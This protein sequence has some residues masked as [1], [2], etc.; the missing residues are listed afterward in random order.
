[1]DSYLKAKQLL[2]AS[3]LDDVEEMRRFELWDEA[4]SYLSSALHC[5]EHY[6]NDITCTECEHADVVA[7]DTDNC[8]RHNLCI[9]IK[10]VQMLLSSSYTSAVQY[11]GW[12]LVASGVSALQHIT[13]ISMES[14]ALFSYDTSSICRGAVT[15]LRRLCLEG[16]AK[17]VL[18]TFPDA[19]RCLIDE[20]LDVEVEECVGRVVLECLMVTLQR[21][22]TKRAS[23]SAHV[24]Q[25]L[26]PFVSDTGQ[27]SLDAVLQLAESIK[28]RDEVEANM[29]SKLVLHITGV[30]G[31]IDDRSDSDGDGDGDGDGDDVKSQIQDPGSNNE[32]SSSPSVSSSEQ[33]FVAALARVDACLR[34]FQVDTCDLIVLAAH[35]HKQDGDGLEILPHAAHFLLQ[36][37]HDEIMG[38]SVGSTASNVVVKDVE[39]PAKETCCAESV[40]TSVLVLSRV[41]LSSTHHMGEAARLLR[42][43]LE[44]MRSAINDGIV[45]AW[46]V[47]DEETRSDVWLVL[48]SLTA[49]MVYCGNKKSRAELLDLVHVVLDVF[50]PTR[51]FEFLSRLVHKCPF[52]QVAA[53]MLRR[54]KDETHRGLIL[55]RDKPSSKE[56]SDLG[57][58]EAVS[59]NDTKTEVLNAFV[60]EHIGAF[61][62]EVIDTF[63]SDAIDV[64]SFVNHIDLLLSV[65][66][67]FRFL[68]LSDR[69]DRTGAQSLKQDFQISMS[70]Y[71]GDRVDEVKTCVDCDREISEAERF[72]VG[73]Q[74]DML[75]SVLERV[76]EL[77]SD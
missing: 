46:S 54:I 55:S 10:T 63:S 56:P 59:L 41:M 65:L 60:G 67:F 77:C 37:L 74:V 13:Q 3:L 42:E 48:Q 70:R 16:S 50:K 72:E 20:S 22:K 62:R 26:M 1:M 2:D 57:S 73:I 44:H 38:K 49:T 9:P 64:Y 25:S 33:R 66:N 51:Q 8:M 7:T 69:E 29:W 76:V 30:Y 19:L 35:A 12:Q 6:R 68:L 40:G 31:Q 43:I 5:V 58:D 45:C 75:S 36:R 15:L 28:V 4:V 61:I 52:P 71:L 53:L 32:T 47:D 11:L 21:T 27:W 24:V 23:S 17:E 18:L 34:R 14:D 39:P